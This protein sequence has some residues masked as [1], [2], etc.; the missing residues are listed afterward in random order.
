MI[1]ITENDERYLIKAKLPEVAKQSLRVTLDNTT[2]TIS[3]ER[4]VAFKRQFT[5]PHG[6]GWRQ[7]ERALQGRYA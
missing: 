2:L 4:R 7:G 1:D 3:G 5:L 6:R